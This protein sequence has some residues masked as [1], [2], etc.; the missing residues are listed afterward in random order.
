[1][2]AGVEII[3]TYDRSILI[4]QAVQNIFVKLAEEFLVVA[5]VC[6]LFLLH[7]RSTAVIIL[8]LPVGILA[9]FIVMRLQGVNADIMSLSGI[10]IAIG[11]MVDGAIVMVENLHKHMEQD[12]F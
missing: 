2:P 8:T 4:D 6:A 9:A 11:A 3:T 7:F 1:M 5:L 10:A 12:K